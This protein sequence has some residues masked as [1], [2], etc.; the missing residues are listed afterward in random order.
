MKQLLCRTLFSQAGQEA[1]LKFFGSVWWFLQCLILMEEFVTHTFSVVHLFLLA[2]FAGQR[3]GCFII[4]PYSRY[5]C[6]LA[7]PA[8]L[9][10]LV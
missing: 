7:V 2:L 5:V 9:R 3:S 4:L 1:T 10:Y 6:L 8:E